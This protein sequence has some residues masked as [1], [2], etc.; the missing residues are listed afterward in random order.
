MKCLTILGSTGSIGTQT[1]EIVALNPDQLTVFALHCDNNIDLLESQIN[2][3]APKYALVSNVHQGEKLKERYDGK[4]I[5]LVGNAEMD[6]IVTDPEVHIVL[7]SVMG[8]V[9]LIPTLKAIDCGKTIALANKE[10]LVAAGELVMARA[11]D[12]GAQIIPVDSEHSAI[13]QC[14]QG[15]KHAEIDSILLTASGGPFRQRLLETFEAITLENALKHPNWSM[16]KKIT[17]DS[18]SLMNKG[19]EVIEAKWLFDVAPSQIKVVVHPQSIIHSMVQFNDTSVLAQLGHPDMRLPIHYALFYPSRVP[20]K[21][22]PFSFAK[23]PT[24]TF[25]EPDFRR[26]PCLKL[27]FDALAVGGT[28][29]TV[30]NAANEMAVQ[31]FLNNKIRFVDIPKWVSTVMEKHQVISHPTLEEILDADRAARVFTLK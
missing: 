29:T 14:L 26:F 9:G 31:A 12:K 19:L 8:S 23:Y 6:L 11:K 20:S 7:T 4:T 18:A 3:F 28:M 25:E 16:G 21:L 30:L 17:I 10:T 2:A 1:L 13:F 15:T 22:E 5:I 27:A 24:L